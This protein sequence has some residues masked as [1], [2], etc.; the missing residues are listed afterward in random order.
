VNKNEKIM[1]RLQE[2]YNTV[3]NK[4][5]EIVGIF[6]QGSQNYE[7]DYEDSDIDCKA[8]L[9]PKFN[10][11]V[12]N[13]KMVST[14]SIL[15][16]DEHIDLKDIRLMFDCFKKQNI[17]FV[18]ILFTKYKILNPKYEEFFKPML[19]NNEL[20]ARYNNYASV[21]CISGMSMEKYKALEHPYPATMDKIEKFGHDPKQLHHIIRLNEFIKRY[22]N[23]EKYSD[24]L[25][26]KQ[27]D[28]LIDVKKGIHNLTEAREIAK[29]LCEETKQI[30]DEYMN[31]NKLSINKEVE[32]L[33]NQ[34]LL[35]IIKFSF[36]SELLEDK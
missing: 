18:E 21:N 11:F 22:I 9:L 36:K 16:N 13:G 17:N 33:L 28:Y 19:D 34:V 26:S 30:K 6:L 25:I 20:I 32:E 5:Y 23:D 31:N 10:D 14:T 8:I 4:G 27:K 12:L 15:E 2:N 1:N 24:C 3:V 7:L 35:D 29:S